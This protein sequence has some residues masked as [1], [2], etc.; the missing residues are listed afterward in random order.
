[1]R[2]GTTGLVSGILRSAA[3]PDKAGAAVR[4]GRAKIFGV[5]K[6]F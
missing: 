4:L 1:M 6:D 2:D 3:A 5:N